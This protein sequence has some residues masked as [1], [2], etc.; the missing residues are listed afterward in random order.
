MVITKTKNRTAC[1]FSAWRE[2]VRRMAVQLRR[3]W[4]DNI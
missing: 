2:R 4:A 1:Q 3:H